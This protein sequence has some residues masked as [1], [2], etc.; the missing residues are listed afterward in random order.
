VLQCVAVWCSVLQCVAVCCS[1]LQCVAV[2]CSVLQRNEYASR[3]PITAV[4]VVECCSCRVLQ[5]VAACCRV[6]RSP[7]VLPPRPLHLVQ[8]V[9]VC[10]SV[11]QR[12]VM[13]CKIL[14]CA[15]P[16]I[17]ITTA[18]VW[19]KCDASGCE[20]SHQVRVSCNPHPTVLQCLSVGCNVLHRVAVWGSCRPPYPTPRGPTPTDFSRTSCTQ[21]AR[22]RACLHQARPLARL[23]SHCMC[24]SVL[25]G[26]AVWCSV[27][28][29][30]AVCCSVL[31]C[32]AVWCSVLQCVAV[33]CSVLQRDANASICLDTFALYVWR[34]VCVTWHNLL[35][36]VAVCCSVLQCVAVCCSV[37]QLTWHNLCPFIRHESFIWHDSCTRHDSFIWSG[38]D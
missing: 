26:V 30:V 9:A 31:Q 19:T 27:L 24:C 2:C 35:Q 5:S 17:C 1:V 10:C 20:A 32:V 25:Q 29:C 13:C 36:C 6:M 8:C 4:C 3:C 14:Q 16:L 21:R 7:H 33:C 22:R 18:F 15:A 38:Y 34:P 12:A 37:L 28:Q 23:L 11:R